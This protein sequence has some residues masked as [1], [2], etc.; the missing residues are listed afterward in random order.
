[1]MINLKSARELKPKNLN[2]EK[3]SILSGKLSNLNSRNQSNTKHVKTNKIIKEIK[4]NE[5]GK[6]LKKI[7][8]NLNNENQ[9]DNNKILLKA[10]KIMINNLKKYN[11]SVEFLNKKIIT[12]II[13]D[14]R[15]HIVSVFKNYLL[16]DEM[17]DFL[18][19]FYYKHESKNRLP[20]INHYYEKYTL[21][22]PVYYSL[23]GVI[24]IMIKNVKKKKKYLEMVEE[25]EDNLNNKKDI[26]KKEFIRIIN[27]NDLS[28]TMS[29]NTYINPSNFTNTF[30]SFHLEKDNSSK[31]LGQLINNVMNDGDLSFYDN[32]IDINKRNKNNSHE[33][34]ISNLEISKSLFNLNDCEIQKEENKILKIDLFENQINEKNKTKLPNTGKILEIKSLNLQNINNFN[35][36]FL[37]FNNIDKKFHKSSNSDRQQIGNFY[38][39]QFLI[40]DKSSNLKKKINEKQKNNFPNNLLF[41]QKL[42]SATSRELNSKKQKLN[43]INEKKNQSIEYLLKI[44]QHPKNISTNSKYNNQTNNKVIKQK[45]KTNL[46]IQLNSNA[47][48]NILSNR[49]NT[50]QNK[51]E[52]KSN[53]NTEKKN[54]RKNLTNIITTPI[55]YITNNN[56]TSSIYN[57]NLNVN[58]GHSL[59]N[60]NKSNSNKKNINQLNHNT[61][62]NTVFINKVNNNKYKYNNIRNIIYGN[63]PI[64]ISTNLNMNKSKNNNFEQKKKSIE[65]KR[66]DGKISYDL[67]TGGNNVHISI[68]KQSFSNNNNTNNIINNNQPSLNINIHCNNNTREKKLSRND[69]KNLSN[70]QTGNTNKGKHIIIPLT[71]NK[72]FQNHKLKPKV[73]RSVKKNENNLINILYHETSMSLGKLKKQL[74]IQINKK[75]PLTSRNDKDIPYD[76]ISK[77]LKK[78]K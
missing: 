25:N 28:E 74:N 70:I 12:D 14:E 7:I 26:K 53:S 13:F 2:R 57:I 62:L 60:P 54:K 10:E 47:N 78:I 67:N 40:N 1:M 52:N 16:W 19:R 27:P 20:K 4:E 32:D 50:L 75:Y 63:P 66:K 45:K 36:P 64:P 69:K 31:D 56:I 24:K 58:L 3:L 44:V 21:F 30:S 59:T 77:M 39:N 37:S 55:N 73:K 29:L 35:I 65:T 72:N 23:E 33:I 71:E 43:K 48:K 61:Y 18:N 8:L 11:V 34:F 68:Q 51:K 76:L 5:R 9:V 38:S 41:T 49:N 42:L 17:S 46:V 6:R 15:K 22:P